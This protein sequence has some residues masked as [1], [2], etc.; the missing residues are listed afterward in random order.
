MESSFPKRDRTWALLHWEQGVL[1]PGPPGKS[2]PCFLKAGPGSDPS[3][4]PSSHLMHSPLPTA[5]EG[6]EATVL[7][8]HGERDRVPQPLFS[9][10]SVYLPSLNLSGCKAAAPPGPMKPLHLMK[11]R[12]QSGL[13][14][15]ERAWGGGAE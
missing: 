7:I 2:L 9:L 14:A 6:P 15:T 1:A 4:V 10:S 8:A 11:V 3:L 13:R 12:R 5:C